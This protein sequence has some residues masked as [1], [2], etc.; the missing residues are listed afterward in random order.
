M[1]SYKGTTN[2]VL[3]E[4]QKLLRLAADDSNQALVWM[5]L[6]M[7]DCVQRT[8][9][10]QR[11]DTAALT[12]GCDTFTLPAEVLRIK[13][14]TWLYPDGSESRPLIGTDLQT[15]LDLRRTGTTATFY[16]SPYYTLVGEDQLE[17]W[18]MP[19]AGQSLRFWYVRYPQ[20]LT[21]SPDSQFEIRE[22]W[23]SKLALYSAAVEA[24]RFKKDPLIG[25]FTA[26][27]GFWLDSYK[28]HMNRGR[29]LSQFVFAGNDA[30]VPHDPSTDLYQLN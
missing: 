15:M 14:L 2:D 16:D 8:E 22:P 27:Y 26:V 4:L 7:I 3:L 25:E 13:K 20:E 1:A 9:A 12:A 29:G 5:N 30:W 17:L 11:T 10:L 28:A 19:A 24:A 18:P 23:G 6:G 21:S